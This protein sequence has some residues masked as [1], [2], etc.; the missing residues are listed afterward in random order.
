MNAGSDGA[1]T[2]C[3]DGATVDLFALLAGAESGGT[4]TDPNNAASTSTYTPGTSVP[5]VYTYSLTALAPCTNDA[6]TVTVTQN[7]PVNA[8]SDGAVTL[9]VSSPVTDLFAVLGG[10]P[11]AGGS[12]TAPDGTAHT[13]AFTPG[14]DASG[15]YTYS[16]SAIP[17]CTNASAT[18]TVA[19][20]D[21]PDPGSSGAITLCLSGTTADLFGM[22]GGTPDAGG[23]WTAPDGTSHPSTVDPSAD[24][25]GVY[26][27][28]IDVPPPC[29]SVSSTVT[30]SLQ[31]PPDAGLNGTS[32]LCVTSPPIDLFLELAGTPEA[33]GTWTAQDGSPSDGTFT[34][35]TSTPGIYT[36]TVPGIAPCPLAVSNVDVTVTS[37]P[38]AGSPGS[39]TLCMVGPTQ[40]LF[41]LLGGTPDQGGNWT[42]PDGVSHNGTFDPNMDPP[43]VYVYTL[44]APLP[45]P[46]VSSS[47]TLTVNEPPDPGVDGS[48][49]LCI[50]SPPSDLFNSLGG[51]PDMNG[52]WSDPGG[53]TFSGTFDPGMNIP[54]TYTYTVAGNA[55]CPDASATVDVR[56]STYPD[57]GTDATLT[58]CAVDAPSDLFSILGGSPDPGG[59]WTAPDGSP[60][61]AL[62]DPTTDTPGTYTYTIAVPAPCSSVSAT[63]TIAVQQPPS[64][65]SDGSLSLC[66]S[67]ASQLLSSGLNGAPDSGGTWTDP[68]GNTTDATFIPGTDAPGNYTY[69]VAGQDPCPSTSANVTITVNDEPDAGLDGAIVL[70]VDGGPEDL[71]SHLGGSPDAGGQWNAPDGTLHNGNFDPAI[72]IEGVYSYTITAPP[73]C[74]SASSSVIVAVENGPDPGTDGSIMLCISDAPVLLFNT[75][76]GTPDG[77]GTWTSPIGD[78]FDGIFDPATDPAGSYTYTLSGTPPCQ[79]VQSIVEVSVNAPA[80]AGTTGTITACANASSMDLF[81]HLGGDPDLNGVWTGPD[82]GPHS[83]SLDPQV[84]LNGTYT[85]SLTSQAPCPG[86]ASVVVVTIIAPPDPGTD[87]DLTL[88][89]TNSIVDLF[90]AL[91]GTPEPNGTWTA[92]GGSPFPGSLD[93]GSDPAGTYTYLVAGTSPCPNAQAVIDVSMTAASDAGSD[94]AILLCSASPPTDLLTHLNGTPQTDGTWSDPDGTPSNGSFDP[95]NDAPGTYTYTVPGTSPCP[96]ASATV[97]VNVSSDPDAG[98]PGETTLC[99]IAGMVD[100]LDLLEGTPDAGGAWT[101]PDGAPHPDLLDP[102]TDPPGTYSYLIAVPPPCTSASSTVTIDFVAPA[103][104]GLDNTVVHCATD[105]SFDLFAQLGGSPDTDGAWSLDGQPQDSL[106]NPGID[107]PGNYLYSVISVAPCPAVTAVVQVIVNV[108]PDPGVNGAAAL[109]ASGDPIPLVGLLGGTPQSGGTWSF[110]GISHGDLIDPSSDQ[111]GTYSYTVLGNAPCP[112][113]VAT[114]DIAIATEPDPG[115][116]GLVT[117]CSSGAPIDLFANLGGTPDP[118]GSW[119]GPSPSTEGLFDPNSMQ[120]GIYT[121]LLDVPPPCTSASSTVTVMAVIPP[122]AGS[123][124]DLLLCASSPITGLIDVL[125]GDPQAGGGWFAPNGAAHG[126]FFNPDNDPIGTYVYIVNG[127]APC[128]SDSA[129][130]TLSVVSSPDPGSNGFLSQC[131]TDPPEDLFERLEGTPEP[132]GSWSGP[133][134]CPDG[135]FHAST[136][137]PGTYFYLLAAPP[138]CPDTSSNVLVSVSLPP[139]PGTDG[140]VTLCTTNAVTDLFAQLN[141]TPQS[142]GA[143]TAP[144]GSPHPGSFLP[145]QDPAGIYTYTVQ[146]ND[147][148]PAE[149]ATVSMTLH[150]PPDAGLDGDL[151]LC[152][153]AAVVDLF[154]QLGGLPD[155]GGTWALVGGG[156]DDGIFDPPTDQSGSYTYTVQGM[157][158]CADDTAHVMVIVSPGVTATIEPTDAICNGTCSGTAT[159]NVLTG[160]P[161]YTMLWSGGVADD[162]ALFASGLCEGS[163]SVAITD[164]NGC[165]GSVAYVVNEPPPLVIDAIGA[166]DETCIG[167][168]DG[169]VNVVDGEGVLFSIDQGFT[170]SNTNVLTGLCAGPVTVLMQDANGCLA[171]ATTTIASPPPVTAGFTPTPDTMNV[172]ATTVAFLNQSGNATQFVWDFGGLGTSTEGDPAFT[173]P[174]ALGGVYTVCL[175]AMD[176]NGCLDS[177]CLPIVV[178][179]ELQV[180]VPNAFTPNGDDINEV[181]VPVLNMPA[182]AEN[183]GFMIFDRWGLRLFS[184]EQAG[185]GWDGTYGGQPVPNDVYVW[186]VRCHDRVTGKDR[187]LIGHVTVIR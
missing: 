104:P 45:C 16:L 160:T 91:G 87:A 15:A 23:L 150:T 56:V 18:V 83:G 8:G 94:G 182:S 156:A 69:T 71:F 130:A 17:P 28:T 96:N 1:I 109:C 92:P 34:P 62:F 36:Y 53:N 2:V 48:L 153:E 43:G 82:G 178:L 95:A 7:D 12:W 127:M 183:Y 4:W 64:A 41:Y 131:W 97:L 19:V 72:D 114:V 122:D 67:G 145:A 124:S 85:Y 77:N 30:L 51:A 79:M 120:P 140:A 147:P 142:G 88:C 128:P 158:P 52:S 164:A 22:L 181:F 54:G 93:P 119:S 186:K 65:G 47:V 135:F 25:A 167:D 90:E 38:D 110:D 173:F 20:V 166:G 105:P 129:L 75:L 172:T 40:E 14:L 133:S 177:V 165:T 168:C 162:P 81:A 89:T 179:D 26:T 163:Y 151:T 148:C 143:W 11:D 171:S 66:I 98:L 176:A 112:A 132:G 103:D 125:G 27:Y 144:D 141:G 157:A 149:A 170:W 58:L 137:L 184:T 44:N 29:V 161:G 73:P 21:L 116:S 108:P 113:E 13:G 50:S 99:S 46:T 154:T 117:V 33:G 24:Q 115:T 185:Q 6:A 111:P 59:V 76:G 80:D 126:P 174:D 5:G 37:I 57:P 101:G 42:A 70:C 9:C 55:P 169:Y 118:G 187:D 60:H 84:D 136:M 102:V 68:L 146:G 74:S 10:T 61:E 138:P 123:D 35:G 121:Y 86:D 159:L 78:P 100:L 49:L 155:A 63:V 139:D 152:P 39:A 180:S 175:T 3:A 32:L 31:T 134:P 106:F 107:T